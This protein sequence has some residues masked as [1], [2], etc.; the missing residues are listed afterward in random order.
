MRSSPSIAFDACFRVAADSASGCRNG[1][2]AA[3]SAGVS[4]RAGRR[5]GGVDPDDRGE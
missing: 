5:D 4:T 3:R 1:A 2:A